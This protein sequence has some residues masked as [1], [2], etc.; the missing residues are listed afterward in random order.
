MPQQ[1]I[2]KDGKNVPDQSHRAFPKAAKAW[3]SKQPLGPPEL[4]RAKNPHYTDGFRA[5]IAC[6]HE[7]G[8]KVEPMADGE[9]YSWPAGEINV[10]NLPELEKRCRI[11]AFSD[12]D[13]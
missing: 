1:S 6:M 8:V 7:A 13:K 5:E 2:V 11:E 9:G 4:D 10:P 3:I 12:K